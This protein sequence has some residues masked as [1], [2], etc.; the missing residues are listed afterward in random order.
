[1]L[2]ADGV[3]VQLHAS[4]RIDVRMLY[5]DVSRMRIDIAPSRAVAVTPL[6]REL[7]ERNV[8]RGALDAREASDRHLIEVIFDEVHALAGVPF[9]LAFPSDPRALRAAEHCL[10]AGDATID[11]QRFAEIAGT[12]ART[13]E[14]LFV[15][16]TG[17]SIGRWQRRMRL[18]GAACSLAAG[19]SLND[20][21]FNAGYAS[22]SAFITAFRRTFGMT[23]GRLRAE[24]DRAMS[25][26][27]TS[28]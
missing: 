7:I 13:L 8:E 16:Q 19:G 12:S 22:P 27:K 20:S 17:C 28:R 24:T 21:A 26:G 23:P 5:L 3:P 14:R 2:V 25:A 18:L 9:A 1:M 6:L 10:A 15:T 11:R 4:E